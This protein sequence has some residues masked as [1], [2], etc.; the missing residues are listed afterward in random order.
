MSGS[1]AAL[2]W[3]WRQGGAT[4]STEGGS[5][6]PHSGAAQNQRRR[7]RDV[8]PSRTSD[9]CKTYTFIKN[10]ATLALGVACALPI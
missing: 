5:S 8:S 2:E 4:S 7:W 6:E 1:R 3:L 10:R 9:E